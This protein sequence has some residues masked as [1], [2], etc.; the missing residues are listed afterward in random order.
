MINVTELSIIQDKITE[1]IFTEQTELEKFSQY[2]EE[3]PSVFNEQQDRIIQG[4]ILNHLFNGE[5]WQYE[6]RARDKKAPAERI[7]HVKRQIDRLNQSRNDEVERINH[8][9]FELYSPM[10]ESA[11]LNTETPGSVIDR[12]SILSLKTF[13]M[14]LQQQREGA[15]Q[16]HQQRCSEKLEVLKNQVNDLRES[17]NTLLNEIDKGERRFKLYYQVKMYNDPTLNPF[18][19]GEG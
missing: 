16:E 1:K 8:N 19:Q 5:L 4:V 15:S 7:A 2:Y 10:N 17:L 12:L 18:M 11:V 6:D 3:V 9:L 13:N 14:K